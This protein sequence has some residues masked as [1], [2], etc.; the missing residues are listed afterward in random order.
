MM[1]TIK[2]MESERCKSYVQ[3]EMIKLGIPYKSVE[4]GAVKLKEIIS[5]EKLQ[6][7]D[8]ALRDAGLE[9]IPDKKTQLIEKIKS[10]VNQLIYFSDE[11]QKPN[12]SRFISKKVNHDYTYLSK[13]FA[14]ING[15][16]IEKYIIAQKIERVKKLIVNNNNNLVDIAFKLQYSSVA[17]LSA[18]FK[19]ITGFTPSI[20]KELFG[21]K[22]NRKK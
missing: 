5:A 21:R 2:N 4:L 10:A 20:F 7:M 6:Q 16:T 12:I 13:L 18:Q 8:L 1:L 9:I 22:Q 19:R 17:H 11:L 15:T 14:A 3:N